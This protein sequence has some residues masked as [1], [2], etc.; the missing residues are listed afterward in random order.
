M[1]DQT[2]QILPNSLTRDPKVDA[3]MSAPGRE[4][5]FLFCAS[6]GADGG[7]VLKTDVPNREEFAFYLCE[8]CAQKYGAI[9]G[10]WVEPDAVFFQKVKEAQLEREGRELTAQEVVQILDDPNSYLNKLAR[11]R[12]TFLASE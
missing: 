12:N 4:W 2:P 3:S 10:L 6:C 8:P 5:F 7:R 9:N 11:D 1:A